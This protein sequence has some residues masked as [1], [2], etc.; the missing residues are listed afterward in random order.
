MFTVRVWASVTACRCS[1]GLRQGDDLCGQCPSSRE[2]YSDC[3]TTFIF[4]EN[5]HIEAECSFPLV[6][7][8][9]RWFDYVPNKSSTHVLRVGDNPLEHKIS[10]DYSHLSRSRSCHPLP[11]QQ[12]RL[13]RLLSPVSGLS[14]QGRG[15]LPKPWRPQSFHIKY[16][17]IS[18]R[19]S[20]STTP[21]WP[22]PRTTLLRSTKQSTTF[23]KTRQ[24]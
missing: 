3:G 24:R 5:P 19:T 4:V 9:H 15:L 13:R 1:L 22:C 11:L 23:G 18:C 8:A 16:P 7:C 20:N 17:K 6:C 10:H 2:F 14:V 21:S 12:R